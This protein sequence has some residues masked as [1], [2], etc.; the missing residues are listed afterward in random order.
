MECSKEYALFEFFQSYGILADE[1]DRNTTCV[2]KHCA[3]ARL[4]QALY[5]PFH[6]L[7]HTVSVRPSPRNSEHCGLI[8]QQLQASKAWALDRSSNFQAFLNSHQL[9]N[10]PRFF[11]LDLEGYISRNPPV[12][13]QVAAVDITAIDRQ[14]EGTV[15]N[16]NLHDAE[17]FD[18]EGTSGA[19]TGDF[20]LNLL[21]FG[22]RDY[23]QY[24]PDTLSGYRVDS[25]Q[26]ARIIKDSG[27]SSQDY[28]LVWHPGY[29]DVDGLRY[30]L[31]QA[32]IYEVL[33][34]NEHVIRLNY[35]FRHNLDLPKGVTCALEFLFSIIFPTHPLRS[36]HHD[37]LIDSEKTAIM[38]LWAKD[39]FLGKDF[40]ELRCWAGEDLTVLGS[41]T[42][43]GTYRGK[44]GMA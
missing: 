18:N 9:P 25:T 7:S 4:L 26:A 28:I 34:S 13:H 40:P 29:A 38:A 6:I 16:L 19:V 37:A 1:D 32:G 27:I 10:A 24:K 21:K 35:L 41:K 3:S 5:C 43:Y 33:P 22:T 14:T 23:W 8:S 31:S 2:I 15:F 11:A 20:C 44:T 42:G 39:V 30:V 36:R 12:V 17:H